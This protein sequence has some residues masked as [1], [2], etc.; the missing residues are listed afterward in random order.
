MT[1]ITTSIWARAV[2]AVGA[3]ALLAA[4]GGT[5]DA[6]PDVLSEVHED[7][8]Q[9]E[10][11]GSTDDTPSDSS[12]EAGISAA[13]AATTG[14]PDDDDTPWDR[15]PDADRPQ[16]HPAYKL[17]GCRTLDVLTPC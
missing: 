11:H 9:E 1:T 13:D 5:A 4:C 3:V 16:S 14:P 10:P 15:L 2:L 7:A 6:Q 8:A 12:E 17:D